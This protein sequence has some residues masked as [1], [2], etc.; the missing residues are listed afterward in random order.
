[1]MGLYFPESKLLYAA[2]AAVNERV[3]DQE[4]VP[5]EKLLET[6]SYPEDYLVTISTLR[7]LHRECPEI[8]IRF[9]HSKAVPFGS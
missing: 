4:L 6:Q 8:T 2:D 5:S 9:L 3:L 7:R 1:M